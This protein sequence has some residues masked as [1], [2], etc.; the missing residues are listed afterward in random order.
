MFLSVSGHS[1]QLGIANHSSRPTV[2]QLKCVSDTISNWFENHLPQKTKISTVIYAPFN[3]FKAQIKWPLGWPQPQV[4]RGYYTKNGR[5]I[6]KAKIG[7]ENRTAYSEIKT[8]TIYLPDISV[9]KTNLLLFQLLQ[10]S[11]QRQSFSSHRAAA[12]TKTDLILQG[13]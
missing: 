3:S 12:M 13:S 8:S 10:F 2:L 4:F 6:P 9:W 11:R 1:S 5:L 7:E